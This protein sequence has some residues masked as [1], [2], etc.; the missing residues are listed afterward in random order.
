MTR[1]RRSAAGF[2][3]YFP[4]RAGCSTW[5]IRSGGGDRP[6]AFLPD[7]SPAATSAPRRS[8]SSPPRSGS[9]GSSSRSSSSR[10]ATNS[11]SWRGRD[12]GG[13]PQ[14]RAGARSGRRARETVRQR[15]ARNCARRKPSA[16][17][18]EPA[19]GRGS[20]CASEGGVSSDAGGGRS[21][22]RQGS[23][24]RRQQPEASQAC[25][26]ACARRSVAASSP[27]DMHGRSRRSARPTTGATCRGDRAT[28]P[29][30]AA[31]REAGGGRAGGAPLRRENRRDPFTRDAEEKL[32]RR[33][34]TRVHIVRSGGGG[35]IEITFGSEEELIGLFERLS[36][37]N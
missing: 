6:A 28:G 15:A 21:A 3:R 33:L 29:F 20:L 1:N 17:G 19:R 30:G 10:A 35:K 34:S 23:G 24:E 5:N 14:S 8:R 36:G 32:S 22:S 13:R 37:K 12:A 11:R 16:G 31:D 2:R 4:A 18:L 9:R 27:P 26:P 7:S 25:R